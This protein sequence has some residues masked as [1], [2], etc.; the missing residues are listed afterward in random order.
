MSCQLLANYFV[1]NRLINQQ[2]H[3]CDSR[4]FNKI[5]K[6]FA[7]GDQADVIK[8]LCETPD[9]NYKVSVKTM[10]QH[11]MSDG[12]EAASVEAAIAT[13]GTELV[14]KGHTPNIAILYGTRRCRI[15][16]DMY[17]GTDP[18]QLR[19]FYEVC[20]GS[21][22]TWHEG[23]RRTEDQWFAMLFQIIHGLMALH[24]A[25][26]MHGDLHDG[27][28]LFCPVPKTMHIGYKVGGEAFSVPTH[29]NLFKIYDFGN[30]NAKAS[31]GMY[32]HYRIGASTK[33]K[34]AHHRE[35][36]P[37][38][39]LIKLFHWLYL[40]KQDKHS[41]PESVRDFMYDVLTDNGN[42]AWAVRAVD[43][44]LGHV[45]SKDFSWDFLDRVP[46][47]SG[48]INPTS[49]NLEE[50]LLWIG[51]RYFQCAE[52]GECQT[53]GFNLRKPIAWAK[54]C[55]LQREKK[56]K[57]KSWA[58]GYRLKSK[59]RTKKV[60]RTRVSKKRRAS[61]TMDAKE[62]KRMGTNKRARSPFYY[63]RR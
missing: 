8:V 44:E 9:C 49:A 55:G 43:R 47:P 16:K 32:A 11:N 60:S 24:N 42:S 29:G 14:L 28:V 19:L 4:P 10:M 2:P 35:F 17:P 15:A 31:M 21:L 27:N 1:I 51:R 5:I 25:K 63:T 57:G 59:H 38:Y 62:R 54:L 39:D 53:N 37:D 45:G 33:A 20:A 12:N 48:I 34:N 52:G 40:E 22:D 3:G 41:I 61:R 36:R 46:G 58:L 26:I 50:L 13:A 18:G 6:Y 30:A 7:G 23:K 56:V